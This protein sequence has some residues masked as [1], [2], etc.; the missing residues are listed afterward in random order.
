MQIPENGFLRLSQIL[1]NPKKGVPAIIPIRRTAWYEGIKAGRY[2]KG[3][4]IGARAM[5]WRVED[6]RKL[7]AEGC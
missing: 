7:I 6:I 3:V 1:G 5:G 4:K 2:P